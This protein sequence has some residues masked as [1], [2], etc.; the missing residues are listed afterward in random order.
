MG[1]SAAL[2]IEGYEQFQLPPIMFYIAEKRS[3][4]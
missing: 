3:S 2:G 4:K 1:V